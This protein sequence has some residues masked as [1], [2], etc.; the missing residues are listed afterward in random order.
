MGRPGLQLHRKMR[1]LARELDAIA[2]GHGT[3]LARGALEL[4][5]D[6][7]Y[8][9]GD[10]YLGEPAD[11]EAR[12]DWGGQ[13]G[14]LCTALVNAGGKG[15]PGFIEEGG[16]S[17]WPDGEPG[18]FRIHD[19]FDHAP[20][21][22]KRRL[23]REE[24]RRQRGQTIS[25]IRAEAGRKGAAV[26]NSKRAAT[27]RQTIDHLP[28]G[29]RQPDDNA[30][31]KVSTPAPAPAPAPAQERN[32]LS[33]DAAAPPTVE[34]EKKVLPLLQVQE[35]SPPDPAELVYQHWKRVM[36]KNG[37]TEF[38]PKR[39][40]A[41]LA[42]LKTR[43]K[44]ADLFRAVDGC[45]GDAWHMEHGHTDLGLICRDDDHVELFIGYADA[46][47]AKSSATPKNGA[48]DPSLKTKPSA[49]E[50]L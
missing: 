46:P 13:T 26:T 10:A 8:E 12:A 49:R 9:C 36:R 6:G 43:W 39:R 33:A 3:L 35:P 28:D 34:D 16:S 21:Y 31:A 1:R 7:C 50:Y 37:A 4:L 44:V 14:I 5:W 11:V 23:D 29:N 17:W 30:S 40:R 24:E 2:P 45:A 38:T 19:L 48:I 22:V 15:C 47:R 20:D 25:A 32:A 42:R 27:G 18:T 41:V